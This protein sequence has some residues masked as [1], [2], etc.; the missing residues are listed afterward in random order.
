MLSVKQGGIK[1]HFLSLWYDSTWD[2]TQVSRAIGEDSNH[3]ANVRYKVGNSNFFNLTHKTMS[4]T[5]TRTTTEDMA[6]AVATTMPDYPTSALSVVNVFVVSMDWPLLD[7]YFT[8]PNQD[9]WIRIVTWNN[10]TVSIKISIV[11]KV[12]SWRYNYLRW[13][14][15]L[16]FF[17]FFFFFF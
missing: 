9:Y 3:H 14:F 16:S 15:F 4:S 7:L 17:F 12:I 5:M 8:K 1:Y 11:L 13:F 10:V 2:W 6:T